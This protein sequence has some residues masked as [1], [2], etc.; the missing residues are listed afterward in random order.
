MNL[1]VKEI[2]KKEV[3]VFTINTF[4]KAQ[5][6][7]IKYFVELGIEYI[8]K[9]N[10]NFLKINNIKVQNS[11]T[12]NDIYNNAL[13]EIE[14]TV[15]FGNVNVVEQ[16]TFIK[17]F[18]P[19]LVDNHF[20]ILNGNRFIPT[21]YILDMPIIVKKKS[22]KLTGLFN[23]ITIYDR[24]ITFMGNNIPAK[25]FLDIILSDQN[26][27]DLQ[28]KKQFIN[29][30]NIPTTALSESDLIKYFSSLFRCDVSKED[31][32]NYINNIFFDDY[33]KMVYKSCY[34]L[35]DE[36][37]NIRHLLKLALDCIKSSTRDD[38]IDLNRKRVLFLEILLTPVFK[39]IATAASQAARG[40]QV[41]SI[42]MDQM[43]IVK[44]FQTKLHN[45]FIY[46]CCNAFDS[47]LQHK[48]CML[49]PNAQQSPEV[50]ANLHPTHYKRICPTSVSSQTP[51]ETIY[52][53]E[54]AKLD[55]FGKFL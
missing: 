5:Y 14:A 54:D 36:N 34:N 4:R 30:F 43:E 47:I 13:T 41:N 31:I 33:S 2:P 50:I 15:S 1:L 45:K 42:N 10:N 18:I 17:F 19:T 48:A 8:S 32:I 28:L 11:V 38:F 23:S 6:E 26:P 24:L 46:D 39:R 51:G 20:F 3:G 35:S 12:Y 25:H 37:I 16:K 40:F 22:I 9:Q 52:I 21:V 7:L 49:N 29:Y 55:I 44:H 27:D 53:I